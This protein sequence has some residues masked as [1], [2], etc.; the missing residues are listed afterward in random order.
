VAVANDPKRA[1]AT[2][3]SE[4][5]WRCAIEQ[6]RWGG[7]RPHCNLHKEK[8]APS[9]NPGRCIALRAQPEA[10]LG[11]LQAARLAAAIEIAGAGVVSLVRPLHLQLPLAAVCQ[12]HHVVERPR[13]LVAVF[14]IRRIVPTAIPRISD[15]LGQLMRGHAGN[16]S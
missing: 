9:V 15:R 13:A 2:G 7:K 1:L 11:L 10:S 5:T 3:R 4:A 6:A 12:G 8:N 14:L 16:G